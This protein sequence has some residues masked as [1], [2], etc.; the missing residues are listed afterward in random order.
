MIRRF[1]W[2]VRK[3]PN[4][5]DRNHFVFAANDEMAAG[6]IAG[7]IAKSIAIPRDLGVVG[8]DD[9]R[10]AEMTR[11]RLTTVHVPMS[12]MGATA[13][14]LLCERIEQPERPPAK[15]VLDAELVVRES[16]GSNLGS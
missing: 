11:P 15:V 1:G 2:R 8:F 12:K 6:I 16:C 13:I 5:L 7:A 10:I 14:K 4:G 3:L 9:T